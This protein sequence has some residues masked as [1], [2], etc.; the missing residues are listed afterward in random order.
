M[1]KT[2]KPLLLLA[3]A[4]LFMGGCSWK[5]DYE[6]ARHM[7]LEEQMKAGDLAR[8]AEVLEEQNSKYQ[9]LKEENE[10]L[11]QQLGVLKKGLDSAWGK[12][13]KGP[14]Q[15]TDR[16]VKVE[17]A[18]L[19]ASGSAALRPGGEA[20]L[21]SLVAK[22]K[23]FSGVLRIEGHTDNDP[24]VRS[25][26]AF[27]SNWHLSAMRALS[28]LEFFEREGIPRQKMYMAGHSFT[29]P[30]DGGADVKRSNATP[31]AK[32]QNRRVELVLEQAHVKS[33]GGGAE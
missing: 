21:R 4:V 18:A 2:I 6:R 32:A 26:G 9:K 25:A 17:G 30:A 24:I 7:Y 27:K 16:G 3:C 10:Q 15:R 33:I 11:R 23:T 31:A 13:G 20:L 12:L 28:V 8:R 29:R 19:F 1:N 14:I 22:I 5:D